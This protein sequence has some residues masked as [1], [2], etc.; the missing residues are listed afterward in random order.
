MAVISRPVIDIKSYKGNIINGEFVPTAKTRHS[1]DPATE[2]PLFPAP[3]AT[4]ED[5]DAAVKHASDAFKT[6]SQTTFEERAKL[7]LEYADAIEENR[8][9]L[10]KLDTMESG[11][12]AI[13]SKNEFN[14]T[15]QWLR[16]FATMELKD[17]ILDENDERTVYSTH[18]P[19]GVCGAIVPWN[20]PALLGLG[21]VGPALMTG[22]T[23]IMKPSPYTPYTDLKLCEIAMSIFPP[24]VFQALSGD[25]SLGPWMT[26]HPDIKLITFTGSVRTGKLVAA[27]CS[28][29]LKRCVLELGGNDALIVC[30]DVDIPKCLPKIATMS[31]INSGQICMLAKRIYV[32]EGIYDKFRDAMV[33]FTKENIKTGGGFEPGVLVGPIQNK[34]QYDL[35]KDMYQ[36]VKKSGYQ[37][38]LDGKVLEST[39]GYFAEPAIVDNPPDDSRIVVEEPFGPIVPL[40]KWSSDDEVIDRANSLNLGLGA[41]VWS[42]DLSRAEKM[43]RKLSAGSVWVNSHFDVAP[44]VPFG[45]TKESGLGREWGIEGFKQFTDHTSL[46]V[47]KKIFE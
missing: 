15:I 35:V 1:I 21:K 24:G 9:E 33:E 5:L 38:A 43:A 6:W 14:L 10:E 3:L 8:E 13:V 40:L 27:S 37:V 28:K 29:T 19:L 17:E 46:W 11:K 45:G 30:E 39:T 12:P 23:I 22:N 7:M 2:Q 16:T 32:H 47:W 42:K 20:W 31:F 41:S 34:M 44:N 18:R 4:R 26:E 36:D 25:D